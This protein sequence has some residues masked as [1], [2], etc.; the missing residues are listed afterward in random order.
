MTLHDHQQLRGLAADIFQAAGDEAYFRLANETI[1]TA[2]MIET[3]EALAAIDRIVHVPRLDSVVLG[4]YDLSGALDRLGRVDSPTVNDAI[5][6]VI[7]AAR[8]AGV[9][10]GMGMPIDP[11]YAS[12]MIARGVNWVQLGSDF[13][14]MIQRVDGTVGELRRKP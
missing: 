9:N 14:Y 5:H 1:F 3:A 2:V 7:A 4:P 13:E 12:T 10:V 11:G 6:R 8:A